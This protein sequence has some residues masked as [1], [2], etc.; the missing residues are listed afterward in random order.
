M[1]RDALSLDDRAAA[2]T[3][4]A[5]LLGNIAPTGFRVVERSLMAHPRV[6]TRI[7]RLDLVSPAGVAVRGI[8]TG[9]DRA[10]E[11]CPAV[12]YCHAHGNRYDIGANELIAGRPALL[13][14]PYGQALAAAGMVALCIDLPCFGER[15][16]ETESAA[17]KFHL[18]H[19]STLFGAMLADLAG[20]LSVLQQIDGI[21]CT[22]ISA[23]GISMGATLAFWLG[24]LETR[25]AAVA[26][27]CC[28]ADLATL[29]SAGG[30]DLHGIY[31]TVPGL[32][33]AFSTGEIAGLVAPRPQLACVGLLDP[34]TPPLAVE[35][36]VADLRASYVAMGA[37]DAL[38]THVSPDTG[39]AET[40]AMRAATLQF[41]AGS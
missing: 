20:A 6:G 39:H 16:G 9:P 41:L 22:Q 10:W 21:D 34:L 29:V 2:R 40:P 32:L 37:L 26:H 33:A 8:L 12:I 23:F 11:L 1:T 4:L 14:P 17:A 5:A 24:A 15:Q 28:F 7:E 27:Q 36:A 25:V 35:V 18:W 13:G 30:H 31:M 19:G 38:Q 3:H